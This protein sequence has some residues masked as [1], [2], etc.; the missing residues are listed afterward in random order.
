MIN[1]TGWR[2]KCNYKG[3]FNLPRKDPSKS[4]SSEE[5]IEWSQNVNYQVDAD[6]IDEFSYIEK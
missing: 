4:Y 6:T 3:D 5:T 2:S 1:L